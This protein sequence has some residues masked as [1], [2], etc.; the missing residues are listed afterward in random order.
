MRIRGKV[1]QHLLQ[2]SAACRHRGLYIVFESSGSH[3]QRTKTYA[4]QAGRAAPLGSARLWLQSRPLSFVHTGSRSLGQF[5]RGMSARRRLLRQPQELSPSEHSSSPGPQGSRSQIF[6]F[7]IR[8]PTGQVLLKASRLST[9][10]FR[11]C[12]CALS[13]PDKYR[14]FWILLGP[15]ARVFHSSAAIRAIVSMLRL[16]MIFCWS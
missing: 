15:A 14:P 5:G 12:P 6:E 7:L 10:R 2:I 13:P 3:Q 11:S 8:G 16:I 4:N 9:Y 1:I